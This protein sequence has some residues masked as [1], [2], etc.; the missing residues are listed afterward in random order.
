MLD[1]PFTDSSSCAVM[2]LLLHIRM[3]QGGSKGGLARRDK[4]APGRASRLG[5]RPGV[6]ANI[7]TV[8]KVKVALS[9][10]RRLAYWNRSLNC[11]CVYPQTFHILYG[12]V[13]FVPKCRICMVAHTCRSVNR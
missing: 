11:L 4:K 10:L 2:R 7:T 5:R 3:S 8:C 6:G 12:W 1:F 9:Q 13:V